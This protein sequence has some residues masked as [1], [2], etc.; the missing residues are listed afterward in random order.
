MDCHAFLQGILPTQGLNPTIFLHS[1][2]FTEELPGSGAAGY[3]CILK[4]FVTWCY[5]LNIDG[6][7]TDFYN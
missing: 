6:P 4:A 1:S 2:N 3:K 5:Q 7:D